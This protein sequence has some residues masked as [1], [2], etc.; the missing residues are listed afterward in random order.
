MLECSL[1]FFLKRAK[2]GTDCTAPE[3]W[4][5]KI[6]NVPRVPVVLLAMPERQTGTVMTI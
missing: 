6:Q 5:E 3:H 1:G 4:K 2:S